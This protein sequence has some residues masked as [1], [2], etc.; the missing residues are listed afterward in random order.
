MPA[1]SLQGR[2]VFLPLVKLLTDHEIERLL[3]AFVSLGVEKVRITGGE[4]L[5]RPGLP[6]LARAI[7]DIPGIR[8]LALTT[9]GVLLPR[10]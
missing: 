8:D 1:D 7:A 5:V 10:L 2:G 9:N 3:R 4:P 6:A